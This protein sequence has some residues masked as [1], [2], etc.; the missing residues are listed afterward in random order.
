MLIKFGLEYERMSH[1]ENDH[2]STI[3]IKLKL[4]SNNFVNIMSGYRQWHLPQIMGEAKSGEKQNQE[5]RFYDI[6][7]NWQK[8]LNSK[9]KTLVMMDSNLDTLPSN[10][11]HD[12]YET[13]DMFESY[14][15]FVQKNGLTI[16]NE[17]PK[18]MSLIKKS[19]VLIIYYQTVAK[20]WAM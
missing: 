2:T 4:E 7:E 8:A 19:L 13:R 15:E 6:L 10:T 11:F 3:W 16:H 12:R 5:S 1:W 14:I 18:G 17:E 9:N 20:T